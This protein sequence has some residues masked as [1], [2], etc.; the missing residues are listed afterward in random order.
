MFCFFF[1]IVCL[2][3]RGGEASYQGTSLTIDAARNGDGAKAFPFFLLKTEDPTSKDLESL[4]GADVELV[5][6]VVEEG[7]VGRDLLADL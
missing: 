2:L 7:C 3:D 6:A 1:A 4:A 5:A